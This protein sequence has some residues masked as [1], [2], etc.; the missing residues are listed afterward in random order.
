MKRFITSVVLTGLFTTAYPAA[1]ASPDPLASIQQSGYTLRKLTW[2][3]R[4]VHVLS[5]QAG[6]GLY[7]RALPAQ[8][9]AGK[10][11]T[12]TTGSHAHAVAAVNGQFRMGSTYKPR[13]RTW[14]NGTQVWHGNG[15]GWMLNISEDGTRAGVTKNHIPSW[16]WQMF[17]G[18]PQVVSS[19]VNTG[20]N[21]PYDGEP[22]KKY[23]D[24]CHD[25]SFTNYN[26]RTAVGISEGC[27]GSDT[28]DTCT[29]YLVV[30]DGRQPPYSKGLRLPALGSLMIFLGAYEAINLDGGG[31]TTM[32]TSKRNQYCYQNKAQ[33]CVVN[34]ISIE[35]HKERPVIDAIGIKQI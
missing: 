23:A 32:W 18:Y 35:G 21:W 19:G 8:H 9:Y 3:G 24:G 7:L 13:A 2:N 34:R 29:Y 14:I 27:V 16:A 33:G 5:F 20:E 12:S 6:T 1:L 4:H 17:G 11:K 22:C 15:T 25:A 31:S 30:V 26:P 28:D 10:G